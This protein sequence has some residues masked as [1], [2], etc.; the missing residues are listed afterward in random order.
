MLA[1]S[2]I[3]TTAAVAA[4]PEEIPFDD[5]RWE[6]R[7]REHR[8]EE[9][10]GRPSL[11]IREGLATVRDLE[12][13]DGIIEFDIA[14]G[15]ERGFMGGV[16]RLQEGG[17]GEEFYVRP[18]Q[19]G[20]PDACQYTPILHGLTSWQLYHGEGYGASIDLPAGRW[21]TVRIV[22]AG[23]R[24]EIY[25]GDPETPAVVVGRLKR[26]P[27]PGKVGV[28]AHFAPAHYSRFRVQRGT[29]PLRGTPAKPSPAP[30]GSIRTWEVSAP[31]AE[32]DLAD[33]TEID[34]A[35]FAD[36]GW[37]PLETEET[38]LA[39]LASL[40]GPEE[41]ADTVIARARLVSDRARRVLLRF[42]Y[43]D[44]VRVFLDGALLY[45]GDNGYRTRDFRYLGTIGYFDTVPLSLREGTNELWLAVSES[46]GGWGV[47]AHL[48]A[49]Q[50]VTVAPA[51]AAITA[52]PPASGGARSR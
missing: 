36:T 4:G 33:R 51:D 17:N 5:G 31:F 7:A 30:V 29:F 3:A 43:S 49:A 40:G 39:N 26:P 1:V 32:E 35:R 46:F 50:G 18:H 28:N 42:G 41:G 52:P 10:L 25:V 21:N 14:F 6:V 12:L 11:F 2:L 24:A 44:R 47:Q 13:T 9:H 27:G 23:D 8:F 45:A 22:V 16:W 37:R 15:P 34:P 38:G 48:V 20:K 19:S